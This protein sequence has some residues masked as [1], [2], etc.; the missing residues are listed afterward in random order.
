[1]KKIGYYIGLVLLLFGCDTEDAPDC[2]QRTGDIVRQE[3]EIPDFSRILVNPNVELVIRQG[4]NRA[5][6]I[7]TGDNLINEVTAVVEGDR[8]VLQDDNDCAFFR[9]FNQTKIFVTAPNITEIRS[10]TQFDISSDGVLN[11]PTLRLLS[12]DFNENTGTTT[13]TFHLNINSD[14]LIV[15]GNNITSFFISGRTTNLN[16]GIF[17]GT[18]RFEAAELVADDV[19]IF[20]R[21]TNKVII[22]PQL[23]LRGSIRSTGDVIAV[24]RPSVVEVEQFFTGELIFQ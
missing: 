6:V 16:V 5:V 19:Q 17:S 11:Y 18:G 13:G 10:A 1:M 24:N 3:V 22:N 9:D 14:D 15:V 21:G 4:E 7:E 2:F 8:L 23:S 12:E 20:H